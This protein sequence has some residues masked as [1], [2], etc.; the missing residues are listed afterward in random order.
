[1]SLRHGRIRLHVK[2]LV[3]ADR[4]LKGD[5]FHYTLPVLGHELIWGCGFTMYSVIMGHLGSDAV[6][7]NS[8][9]NI[10]KNLIACLCLG[11]GSGGGIIVGNDLGKWNLDAAK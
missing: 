8:I 11:L 1:E 6:A 3:L 10:V 2:Y 4:E 7:A 5:F 9:A